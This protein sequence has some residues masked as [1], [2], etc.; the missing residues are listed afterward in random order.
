[1]ALLIKRRH[2]HR[3]ISNVLLV[4]VKKCGLEAVSTSFDSPRDGFHHLVKPDLV[5]T[6]VWGQT[7]DVLVQDA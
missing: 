6:L 2:W 4:N 7:V 5:D 1:M 3:L